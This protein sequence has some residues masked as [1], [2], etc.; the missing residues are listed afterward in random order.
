MLFLKEIKDQA[1]A[2][3]TSLNQDE[4]FKNFLINKYFPKRDIIKNRIESLD[5]FKKITLHNYELDIVK[6]ILDDYIYKNSSNISISSNYEVFNNFFLEKGLKNRE[7]ISKFKYTIDIYSAYI[8]YP[9]LYGLSTAFSDKNI[10]NIKKLYDLI[11]NSSK[12]SENLLIESSGIMLNTS[13]IFLNIGLI[14]GDI[15]LDF[16]ESLIDIIMKSNHPDINRLLEREQ[17]GYK[18]LD[19]SWEGF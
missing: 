3:I 10:K 11:F 4:N 19:N 8:I 14:E 2:F 17:I 6:N 7:I 16:P 5:I 12:S 15:A 18:I 1:E 13:S 9:N